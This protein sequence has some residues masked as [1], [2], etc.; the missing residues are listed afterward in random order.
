[1][2]HLYSPS[3]PFR[4][5]LAAFFTV[6]LLKSADAQIKIGTNGATIAPAS[7]LELESAN[8]GLLLPRMSD[9]VAINALN[10]PNGM[11]IYLTRQP[12]VGLYVRKVTG[13]EYLTGSLGGNGN[14]NSLNVTGTTTAGN[15]SGP[16]TGNAST[17]T[18]A[19]TATNSVNS[20]VTNDVTTPGTTYP[21]FVNGSPGNQP[22][23]TSNS[24]LTYVPATG[25]LTAKGFNG[26]L[27]GDVTGLST[28]AVDAQNAVNIKITDDQVTTATVFPVFVT[29]NAGP[30]PPRVSST[31]L[32]FIPSTGMLSAKGFVG[33]LNGNATSA[34]TAV[35]AT[36]SVN[37]GITNDLQTSIPA[38]PTFVL[39]ASGNLPLRT[40]SNARLS[41]VP[42]TGILTASGFNGPLVGNVTGSSTS[43]V[44]AQNAVNV[45]VTDDLSTS[46]ITYPTFVG[47]TSGP[48]PEKV[49][50]TN[51]SFIPSTGELKAVSFN[52]TLNA[53]NVTG[54][55][56]PTN[57]GTGVS[58]TNTLTLSG[59]NVTIISAAKLLTFL[60]INGNESQVQTIT[61]NGAANGDPVSLGTPNLSVTDSFIYFAWV[62]S[63]NT[64]SV[65][66][67]NL[68]N[69]ALTPTPGTF[70]VKVF[71]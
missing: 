65:R 48:L 27:V 21:A 41:F 71:K 35:N 1:M 47:G 5:L 24:N 37:S 15:F 60:I 69:G 44:D 26:P 66:C 53:T 40:S 49:S 59:G 67:T 46:T 36:N 25:I 16:L 2:R 42:S 23:H 39:S 8:Q 29:A 45:R 10:P 11:L 56:A 57:G 52:G 55:I 19:T 33:P 61:V 4:L 22:L 32:S 38:Y 34:S 17:S 51:L 3:F 64:V 62:S 28:S 70:N 6:F 9:T 31:M 63:A 50:S 18:S 54:F 7:L 12:A 20:A 58:N 30:L 13:W 14:F 43:S 68:T